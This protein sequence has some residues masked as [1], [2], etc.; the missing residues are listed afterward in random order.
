[1]I[2]NK[3]NLLH[4]RLSFK[5]FEFNARNVNRIFVNRGGGF[6]ILISYFISILKMYFKG[7]RSFIFFGYGA[8]PLFVILKILKCKSFAIQ[9]GLNGEGQKE[10]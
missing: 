2:T 10:K 1:M 8:A 5:K 4:Q 3:S 6:F 9:M 7:V